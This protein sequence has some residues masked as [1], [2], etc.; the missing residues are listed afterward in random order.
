VRARTAIKAAAAVQDQAI[1]AR[2]R[3]WYW[4][5]GQVARRAPRL[6][7]LAARARARVLRS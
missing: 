1:R 6:L 4:S 3:L 2:G 7:A 5:Y